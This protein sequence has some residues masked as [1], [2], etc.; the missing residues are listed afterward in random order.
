MGVPF[1]YLKTL[2]DTSPVGLAPQAVVRAQ[3]TA[4]QNNLATGAGVVEVW[5]S[6]ASR[7]VTGVVA[8]ASGHNAVKL[9]T[10]GGNNN[11]VL[12]TES[13]SSTAA[14]RL[15]SPN[16]SDLVVTGSTSNSGDWVMFVYD[17]VRTRWNVV[18]LPG[19]ALKVTQNLIC[20]GSAT[21]VDDGNTRIWLY[22]GTS[23]KFMVQNGTTQ[24]AS[25]EKVCFSNNS[26]VNAGSADVGFNRNSA[27]QIKVNY[28]G[29]GDGSIVAFRGVGTVVNAGPVSDTEVSNAQDGMLGVDSSNGRIYFRYGGSWHYVDQT[30]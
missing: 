2:L 30:A 5:S 25:T 9:V 7:N 1:P 20:G 13:S 14:N 19:A 6:D 4:D 29:A 24:W 3:F 22:A 28:G 27:G 10:N 17:F 15:I 18:K 12:K 26:D 21:V 23:G 11:I 16:G 8:P